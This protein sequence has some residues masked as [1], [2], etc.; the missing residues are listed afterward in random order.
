MDFYTSCHIHGKNL[1]FR[2]IEN[3][4]RVQYK[5]P[6][7]PSLFVKS[8]SKTEFTTLHGD[9]LD[10]IEFGDISDAR[11]FIK[12][13]KDVSNFEIF[14]NAK[15]E[16][17]YIAER[18]KG[19]IDYD[20]SKLNISVIDIEVMADEGMELPE[21]ANKEIT[22]ITITNINTNTVYSFSNIDFEI[23]II[24]GFEIKHFKF[25]NE[26][27]LLT[28]FLSHWSHN[29]PDI[30]SG[31]HTNGYD[32]PYLYNR[33]TKVLGDKQAKKLS[34]WD[35]IR[36]R[37]IK[38]KYGKD[39]IEYTIVGVSSLDYMELYKRYQKDGASQE[40]YTLDFI[41]K[42]E[43]DEGKL[44]YREMGYD[45][46]HDFY[47]RNPQKYIEYNIQDVLLIGKLE[48][49]LMLLDLAL[50][51]SYSTKV[52]FEDIFFQTRMGDAL[53]CNHLREK[54]IQVPQIEVEDEIEYDGAYVKVPIPGMYDYVATLDAS[55]LYPSM[56][57]QYNIGPDTIIEVSE[58][59]DWMNS[60]VGSINVNNLL[61][62][63][64]D[65]SPLKER[66]LT[67]TPN[68]Q[69]FRTDK[70]GF[71]TEL[72]EY[73]FTTRSN[74]KKM[75]LGFESE[76]E[77]AKKDN[78]PTKELSYKVAKYNNLQ[79]AF[80]LVANSVYGC[81][82]SRYFR[83]YDVRLAEAITSAGQL[84]IKWAEKHVNLYLNKVLKTNH[85]YV[86]NIDTDSLGL[87]LG[88]LVSKMNIDDVDKAIKFLIKSVESAIQP[89]VNLT[90]LKLADY[91]N[92]YQNKLNLKIEK[93][94]SRGVYTA[95]KRYALMVYYNE[96]VVYAK[97]QLKVTGLQIVS[98]A[99]PKV[100]RDKLKE[101]VI[102]IMT[103]TEKE[104]QQYV[105][106]FNKEFYNYK[107]EEIAFPSSVNGLSKYK[108]SRTIYT[109][110]TP[111]AVRAALLYNKKILDSK[112]K[113][114][115]ELIQEGEKIKYIYLKMPNTL[116]E[117][118][119]GFPHKLPQEF[120]LSSD[121]D[122]KTMY[123][124]AFKLPLEKITNCVGWSIESRNSIMDF[125]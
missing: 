119:I 23:P 95:K 103:K 35:I 44:D 93:I 57:M 24:P 86:I 27:S 69:F 4:K 60:I 41:A 88:P 30:I 118:V 17:V 26:I 13:Y 8:K 106:D 121:I 63:S 40:S 47:L 72:F 67:V 38:D 12:N 80:K 109:K 102:I 73:L 125:F 7:T 6:Y 19:F 42:K 9:Y 21:T 50:A 97:P 39:I 10:K 14:G 123:D 33:L 98:S 100:V 92:A 101:C 54:G 84:S 15:F 68:G 76:L 111:I 53:I 29:Y 105:V 77:Q 3:N 28:N 64:I 43:L 116:R 34:P 99:T 45:S 22:A 48:K 31:W 114:K 91:I 115:Y 120:N 75:M 122:Y 124:K 56:D 55:S 5:I 51:L 61:S 1:L 108:D 32:I 78:L 112:L 66:N 113:S 25:E 18:Y 2:G 83:F 11:D 70:K 96:G 59:D 20:F 90:V 71:L 82:G 110:G 52:N 117:N 65:L 49:K 36:P 94:C 104:L 79:N 85:D 46:L 81:L 74:F 58:Y 87:H 89:E 62:E 37:N 107:P 16:Y